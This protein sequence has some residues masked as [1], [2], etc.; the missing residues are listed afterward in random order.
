MC[1]SFDQ[2]VI[3]PERLSD[4]TYNEFCKIIEKTPEDI[5]ERFL[6]K[7]WK[8]VVEDFEG[9]SQFIDK[10]KKLIVINQK[11]E[12]KSIKMIVIMFLKF[13]IIEY[14]DFTKKEEFKSMIREEKEYIVKRYAQ[15]LIDIDFFGKI[16]CLISERDLLSIVSK[17]IDNLSDS[18]IEYLFLMTVME[19]LYD[20]FNFAKYFK[21]IVNGDIFIYPKTERYSLIELETDVPEYVYDDVVEALDRLPKFYVERTIKNKWKIFLVDSQNE[22]LKG[23]Y[24][25]H[26]E[27]FRKEIFILANSTDLKLVIWH[28]YGHCIQWMGDH[29]FRNIISFNKIYKKERKMFY[30]LERKE[31]MIKDKYEYYAQSFARYIDNKEMLNKFAPLTVKYM[32]KIVEI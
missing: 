15:Y 31:Y 24:D 6:K 20:E 13:F 1:I 7:E 30:L 8:I 25:G 26:I 5:K 14:G 21:R 4:N 17:A 11:L 18:T 10:K 16:I 22:Y 29:F 12:D 3:N 28:E 23:I 2:L 19:D 32:D 9:P 27:I